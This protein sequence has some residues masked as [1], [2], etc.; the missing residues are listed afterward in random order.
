M[1]SRFRFS[2][3]GARNSWAVFGFRR[4]PDSRAPSFSVFAEIPAGAPP[5]VFGSVNLMHK[6]IKISLT[7]IPHRDIIRH[8][9]KKK[10]IDL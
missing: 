2:V 9:K 3:F 6:R 8:E 1:T 7:G 4:D 5:A 10:K